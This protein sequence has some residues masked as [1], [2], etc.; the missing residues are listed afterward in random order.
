MSTPVFF[1]PEISTQA[2]EAQSSR[3]LVPLPK[4]PYEAIRHAY[5]VGTDTKSE[6]FEGRAETPESPY[7]V[8]PPTCHV[9]ESEGFGMSGVRSTSSD[10]TAP[11]SPDHPLT[12][13]GP[14]LV[15]I[16]CRTAR[17]VV[18]VSPMMSPG[19]SASIAEVAG[20]S[21]SVLH[22]SEED[23]VVEESSD[24]DSE[25]ED[26]ENEGPTAEDEDRAAGDE[27]LAAGEEGPGMGVESHGLDDE[28][29]G[30][31]EEGHSVESDGFG[32][33]EE[34]A[35]PEGQQ[36]AVL[37]VKTAVGHGFGFA[38]EPERSERVSTSRQ[39]TLATWTNP[40]DGIVYIDVL[41][42]P[43]PAQTPPSPEWLSGSFPISPTPSIIPS[44][45]SPP[46]ISPTVSSPIASLVATST[47]T[48]PV[49]EDQF[50]EVGA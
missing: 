27:V 47:A 16:L 13:T 49:D 36:R 35:I 10:S 31:D 23:E 42:Y 48:I 45:I 1:D 12:H 44:P 39:P 21:D 43:P 7:I 50:I 37:V 38:P 14:A 46:M 19:L 9:E 33:R 26:A 15:P 28:S 11:L 25:S 24:S 20:M 6:P 34:K 3:V 41:A 32:L 17:M 29:H 30:L 2:D 4:D 8:A 5:L 18:R 40:K 22:K